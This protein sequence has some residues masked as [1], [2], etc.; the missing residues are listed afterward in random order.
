MP[1][2]IAERYQGKSWPLGNKGG[3]CKFIETPENETYLH[4]PLADSTSELRRIRDG[5]G[6]SKLYKG[7]ILAR[8]DRQVFNTELV[9]PKLKSEDGHYFDLI[10]S[11]VWRIGNPR[12]FLRE[13]GVSF[14][15]IHDAINPVSMET[16]LIGC[17]KAPVADQMRTVIY[18]DLKNREALPACWWASQLPDWAG[19]DWLELVE[20]KAISYHSPTADRVIELKAH[21]R[22]AEIGR[23]AE[24]RQKTRELEGEQQE[25]AREESLREIDLRKEL[26]EIERGNR[27][28]MIRLEHESAMLL[29]REKAELQKLE[30][31]RERA[32]LEGEIAG[33][34][35]LDE[36]AD[37][38]LREAEASELETQN[39]L[40][41]VRKAQEEIAQAAGMMKAAA[42]QGMDGK[43]MSN[44]AVNLSPETL[45][46]VGRADNI[47]YMAA[48]ARASANASPG[49]VSLEKV[50]MKSRDIGTR[51]VKSLRIG[52][53]LEFELTSRRSGHVTVLNIGTSGAVYLLA[54]NGIV[55]SEEA[56]LRADDPIGFPGAPL[57]PGL[58]LYENGPPGWEEM[59]VIVSR[60]PL[61]DYADLAGADGEAPEVKLGGERVGQLVEQLS[62]LPRD[63][64]AAGVLGFVV[65]G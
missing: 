63:D 59:I 40:S 31:K 11:L 13:Y 6:V 28:E 8:V 5:N 44:H 21:E 60:K 47:Q 49:V 58:P 36:E 46:L 9:F 38:R 10:L 7:E 16:L 17:C 22:L 35:N 29:A 14:L 32:K 42:A 57:L 3:M 2:P 53:S 52:S 55:K 18:E 19:F 33:I 41:A 37:E 61:F 64:W 62:E 27:V 24:A 20:V 48:I 30:A 56:R 51:R 54:P 4:R 12:R 50:D 45:A 65:E 25:A 26:S 23:E 1:N 15:K 39:L 34:R 43:R